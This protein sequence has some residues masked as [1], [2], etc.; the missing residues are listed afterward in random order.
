VS[1]I[2]YNT[3]TRKEEMVVLKDKDGE[4]IAV[5]PEDKFPLN[6]LNSRFTKVYQ[7]ILI[8]L[9]KLQLR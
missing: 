8:Q 2:E 5:I 3:Y 7:L 9:K 1:Q 6:L 4:I